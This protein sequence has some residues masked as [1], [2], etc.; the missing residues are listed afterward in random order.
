MFV[1]ADFP[2]V[3]ARGEWVT[4]IVMFWWWI[5]GLSQVILI[6]GP[7]RQASTV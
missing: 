1:L 2:R 3:Q 6:G 4:D 5:P 7:G